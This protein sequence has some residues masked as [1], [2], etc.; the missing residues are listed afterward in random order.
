MKKN[1]HWTT[2]LLL[3]GLVLVG[4][5]CSG[6]DEA[7]PQTETEETGDAI[8]FTLTDG[9]YAL[10]TEDSTLAW[11]AKKVGGAHNGIVSI[12]SG[13]LAVEGG[14][15]TGGSFVI[16]MTTIDVLDL[17]GD[18]ETALIEHLSSED[19]FHV[20]ENGMSKFTVTSA[21]ENA[22]TGDLIIKG[23]TNEISFAY[24]LE[25]TDG[26]LVL[27]AAFPID[28]TLWEIN[29]GSESIADRVENVIIDDEIEY[30]LELVF[31]APEADDSADDA[32]DSDDEDGSDDDDSD[33]DME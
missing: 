16:D 23:I 7:E 24:A 28:R 15:I 30:D 11:S 6:A 2:G 4:A 14:V 3:A 25:M 31:D 13:D 27:T 10:E 32:D 26:D 1:T 12:D 18:D 20:E 21:T 29:F 17:E 8:E 22:L 19:F 9:A 5:G 33:E